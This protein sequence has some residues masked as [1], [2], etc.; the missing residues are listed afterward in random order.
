MNKKPSHKEPGQKK[1]A[2]TGH[3]PRFGDDPGNFLQTLPVMAH[4][5]DKAWVIQDVSHIWLAKMGYERDEVIGR[6][7]IEFL[8]EK[9]RNYEIGRAS[10]RERV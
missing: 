10:C 9:S 6:Q 3:P 7:S 4:S 8:T 1:V 2:V 5:I